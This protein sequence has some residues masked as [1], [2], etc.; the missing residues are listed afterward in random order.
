M[1]AE[2]SKIRGRKLDAPVDVHVE[3]MDADGEDRA[4]T[5]RSRPGPSRMTQGSNSLI[6]EDITDNAT[7]LATRRT[8]GNLKSRKASSPTVGG[9]QP[10]VRGKSTQM[11][12]E[13][14]I[15]RNKLVSLAAGTGKGAH[16]PGQVYL[17][18]D[19]WY[20]KG[21]VLNGLKKNEDALECYKQALKLNSSHKASIFNLACAFQKLECYDEA[22]AQFTQ[23]VNVEREW[24]DAHYG[25]ALCCLMLERYPD[26]LGHILNAEEHNI[27][28]YRKKLLDR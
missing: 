22:L 25:L 23:A 20:H 3:E 28:Q 5:K 9:T 6:T 4:A 18:S 11:E 1:K 21:V 24:P 13:T 14:G 7:S 8:S 16:R 26:A 17:E 19:Y 12:T 10:S 15:K 27:T 2:I